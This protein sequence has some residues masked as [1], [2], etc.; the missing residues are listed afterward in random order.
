LPNLSDFW[1]T[2]RAWYVIEGSMVGLSV[3]VPILRKGLD[4]DE[5]TGLSY[6]NGYGGQTCEVWKS[7]RNEKNDLLKTLV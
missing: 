6:M 7:W 4:I 5:K 2:L 3:Q 1:A